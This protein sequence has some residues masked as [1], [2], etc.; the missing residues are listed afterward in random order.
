M[1]APPPHLGQLDNAPHKF[2]RL[3]QPQHVGLILSPHLRGHLGNMGGAAAHPGP[4]SVPPGV[5]GLTQVLPGLLSTS[6]ASR[7]LLT[8]TQSARR[9]RLR[10]Q[11][12][13]GGRAGP[14]ARPFLQAL[15]PSLV[16]PSPRP[17]FQV[18]CSGKRASQSSSE[19]TQQE[20]SAEAR[21]R[22]ACEPRGDPLCLALPLCPSG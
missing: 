18:H 20:P 14:S 10:P 2:F 4:Q 13:T 3:Q 21:K 17:P 16:Q 12:W 22:Q 9:L 5:P 7:L 15:G 19:E 1:P 8:P 6:P 11:P